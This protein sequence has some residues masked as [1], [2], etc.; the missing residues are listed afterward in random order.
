M[1]RTKLTLGKELA[2]AC[3]M[4]GWSIMTNL[5]IVMLP[6]FYLPPSN[7]RLV[8]LVPQLLLFGVINILSVIAASGRL[9][10]ALYDPFIASLSDKS[11]NPKGRRI[12]FMKWAILPAVVFCCL[13]FYPPVQGISNRNSAF[14]AVTMVLFFMGATTYVIPYNALLPEM[15]EN[16]AEKVRLS[17]YQQAGFVLGII[18]AALVNNYADGVQQVFH[19]AN[20]DHAVQYTI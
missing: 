7:S 15:T 17:S 11:K 16:S 14:L 19:V 6:Y 18:I 2:Y 1:P 20:R 12:P 8:Q 5:V 9:V 13:T 4:V 3:G 10:D